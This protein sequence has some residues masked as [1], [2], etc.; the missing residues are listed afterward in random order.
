MPQHR[1]GA[2]KLAS[3]S[4]SSVLISGKAAS[5]VANRQ[6]IIKHNT[7]PFDLIDWQKNIEA[8]ALQRGI[9]SERGDPVCKVRIVIARHW[10][11]DLIEEIADE[12]GRIVPTGVFEIDKHEVVR[13]GQEHIVEAEVGGRNAAVLRGQLGIERQATGS[14]LG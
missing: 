10:D 7:D 13:F 6:K 5:A 9:A 4:C 11:R 1:L 12:F 8:P 3:L 2:V 14:A